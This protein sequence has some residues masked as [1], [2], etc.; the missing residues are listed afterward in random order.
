MPPGT[1]SAAALLGELCHRVLE[2]MDFGS[3][4]PAGEV[5]RAAAALAHPVPESMVG[6]AGEILAAFAGSEA[7]RELA[8]AEILGR[9]VPLLATVGGRPVS[10]RADLVYRLDSRLF[11]GDFKLAENPSVPGVVAA[12]YAGAVSAA[13]GEPA[14]FALISL[15]S[16]RIIPQ[17]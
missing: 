5:I 2:R 16:G 1:R 8:R 15:Y 6:R 11:V 14:V 7:V 3:P 12:A 17:S 4:D 13:W 9:E 10:A